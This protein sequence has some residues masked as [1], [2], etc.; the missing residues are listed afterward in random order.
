MDSS[1]D[2]KNVSGSAFL[3][4]GHLEASSEHLED[5]LVRKAKHGDTCAF[6]EL[7]VKHKPMVFRVVFKIIRH[8]EDAEDTMQDAFL[9]A[10][11][12]LHQFE[13]NSKFGTWLGK[14]AVNQSLMFLRRRRGL[15]LSLDYDFETEDSSFSP[16][17][18]ETRLNPEERYLEDETAKYLHEA[19][20]RLPS[21]FRSVVILR[22]LE[23]LSTKETAEALGLS[24]PAVKARTHRACCCLRENMDLS[25]PNSAA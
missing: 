14:I 22:Y 23:E 25:R 15:T 2:L 3:E 6:H 4:K 19:V 16:D 5:L 13:G 20:G 21:K 9:Q 12:H 11:R 1:A 18:A 8:R 10:Y 7:V 17:I 24:V